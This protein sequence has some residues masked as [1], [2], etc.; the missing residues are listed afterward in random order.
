M[1]VKGYILS[2]LVKTLFLHFSVLLYAYDSLMF[3]GH[4][5]GLRNV[6]DAFMIIVIHGNSDIVVGLHKIVS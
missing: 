1:D 6:T 5:D 2:G 4:A 3:D